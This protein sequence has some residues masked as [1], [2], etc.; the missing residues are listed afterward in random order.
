[1]FSPKSSERSKILCRL[2][3]DANVSLVRV[4]DPLLELVAVSSWVLFV[5]S[6]SLEVLSTG[7]EKEPPSRSFMDP[8]RSIFMLDTAR[9][10]MN[11]S[12]VPTSMEDQT[13]MQRPVVGVM[14]PTS[15]LNEGKKCCLGDMCK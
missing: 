9:E 2:G 4:F 11:R 8:H 6:G 3:C 1:M 14:L 10:G 12:E 7:V 15:S 5:I 13:G